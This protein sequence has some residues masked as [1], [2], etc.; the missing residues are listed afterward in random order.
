[1]SFRGSGW[2]EHGDRTGVRRRWGWGWCAPVAGANSRQ[3]GSAEARSEF[4][5]AFRRRRASS[6]GVGPWTADDCAPPRSSAVEM[7]G[8]RH[9][10][11]PRRRRTRAPAAR[12]RLRCPR[13]STWGPHQSDDR[14]TVQAGLAAGRGFSGGARQPGPRRSPAGRGSTSMLVGDA[15]WK[16][17]GYPPVRPRRAR[18]CGERGAGYLLGAQASYPAAHTLLER[19]STRSDSRAWTQ[20]R[21]RGQHRDS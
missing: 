1:M 4:G 19:G 14:C 18:R 2:N 5:C 21:L 3:T 20:A 10:R 11:T 13:A 15:V 12:S 6:D 7:E 9:R 8:A 16:I 17:C